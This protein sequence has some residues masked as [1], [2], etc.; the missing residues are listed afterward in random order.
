MKKLFLL[1]VLFLALLTISCSK[2][3]QPTKEE[4]KVEKEKIVAYKD[5]EL[6]LEDAETDKYGIAFS[7]SIG[8][9]YKASEINEKNV[10][11]IDLVSFNSRAFIAFDSPT[12]SDYTKKFK[13]ATVTKIQHVNVAMTTE[14]FDKIEDASVLKKL[15]VKNDEK[16]LPITY[17]GIILFENAKGKKGAL[18]IKALNRDRILFDVKVMK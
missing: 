17:E 4:P 6:K 7:S 8:K 9:T 11:E 18:K 16:V 14:E 10:A 2:E 15:T 1:P 13:G 3:E 5:V 12:R